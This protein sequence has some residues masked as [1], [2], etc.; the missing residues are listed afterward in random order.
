MPTQRGKLADRDAIPGHDERLASVKSAHNLAAV[1]A[2]LPLSNPFG[3]TTS[4]ARVL[5][6]LCTRPIT[7]NCRRGTG[8]GG[9]GVGVPAARAEADFTVVGAWSCRHT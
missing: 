6:A 3:H 1:I 2:Q 5:R 9:S 8:N 4:V 7:S